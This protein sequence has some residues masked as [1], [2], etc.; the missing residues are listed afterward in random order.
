MSVLTRLKDWWRAR[1]VSEADAPADTGGALSRDT[2]GEPQS[3]GG[4]AR[5]TTGAGVNETFVGRVA[6]DDEGYAGPTGAETRQSD[7]TKE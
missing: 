7:D 1:Q 6:G 2:G 3:E 4:D 5:S